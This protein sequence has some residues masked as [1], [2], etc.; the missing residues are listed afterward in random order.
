MLVQAKPITLRLA[1]ADAQDRP[2][3]PYVLAFID[4]VKSLSNGNITV[5]PVWNAGDDTFVGFESGIVQHVMRGDMELGL[6]ASRAFDTESV[7]SFQA[8]QAPFL[9]T[10]DAVS[11]AVATSEIATR[12]LDNLS[13]AGAMGLTLWPEDLRHPFSVIPDK[14]ILAPKDFA[15]LRVRAVPSGAT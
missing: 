14:P 7:R 4:Q 3:E 2:S 15:G 1:I 11:K 9:I 6:T 13:S 10:S 5:E 12:M 8:L